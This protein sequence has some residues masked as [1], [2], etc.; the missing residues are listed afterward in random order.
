[1]DTSIQF[2]I[3]VAFRGG[4]APSCCAGFQ[5]DDVV[6]GALDRIY[7]GF[8][9]LSSL[10]RAESA[11]ASLDSLDLSSIESGNLQLNRRLSDPGNCSNT[12]LV[13]TPSWR[14][15]SMFTLLFKSK[16]DCLIWR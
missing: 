16:A 4:V 7:C 5:A 9:R 1:M 14:G 12:A 15:R 13:S 2:V 11:W 8:S 3:T 6:H 10:Y